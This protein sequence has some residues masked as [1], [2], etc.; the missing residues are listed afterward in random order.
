MD[1]QE[2][3]KTFDQLVDAARAT[4]QDRLKTIMGGGLQ[5]FA[6]LYGERDL[7]VKYIG[8]RQIFPSE[9]N[10]TSQGCYEDNLVEI[11]AT[12]ATKALLREA[13]NDI[14]TVVHQRIGQMGKTEIVLLDPRSIPLKYLVDAN[15][16]DI[17][18]EIGSV[19]DK[20]ETKKIYAEMEWEDFR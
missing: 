5:R 2:I 12:N 17:Y 19:T 1:E 13:Q 18:W 15:L 10:P 4:H 7:I 11:K 14:K 20:K 6:I 9:M 8:N 16:S 3:R